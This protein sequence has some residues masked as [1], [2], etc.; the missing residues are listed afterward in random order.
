[1]KD[2]VGGGIG[3]VLKFIELLL[4]EAGLDLQLLNRFLLLFCPQ[5]FHLIVL[6]KADIFFAQ[7]LDLILQHQVSLLE[8]IQVG[9]EIVTFKL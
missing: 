6:L 7:D 5:L 2:H 8:D 9:G 3:I 4:A 1:M